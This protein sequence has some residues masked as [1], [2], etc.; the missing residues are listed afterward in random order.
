MMIDCDLRKEFEL[1]SVRE[2]EEKGFSDG[3][4]RIAAI[5]PLR[6]AKCRNFV[7]LVMAYSVVIILF[8]KVVWFRDVAHFSWLIIISCWW[9]FR[10]CCCPSSEVSMVDQVLPSLRILVCQLGGYRTLND[11]VSGAHRRENR[12]AVMGGSQKSDCRCSRW[13]GFLI[14]K[15]PTS[16]VSHNFISNSRTAFFRYPQIFDS[17]SSIS[18]EINHPANQY[19]R[20]PSTFSIS[21][22]LLSL[23]PT[24]S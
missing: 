2:L 22:T 14:S 18:I 24:L 9:Y 16:S 3:N 8:Y 15:Q 17:P 20:P 21:S 12:G 7:W 4:G 10:I 1:M 11:R 5:E 23:P 19:V 13:H 6:P